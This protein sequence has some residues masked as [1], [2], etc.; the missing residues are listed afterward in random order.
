MRLL[1]LHGWGFDAQFWDGLAAALP[2][3]PATRM[4]RGYFH[5][6]SAAMPDKPFV[7]ITHSLGTMHLLRDPPANCRGL[8]AINGFDCFT[9][10]DHFPGVS[11][12][13]VTRMLTQLD[14]DPRQVLADFRLKCGTD[15]PFP[16]PD[17]AKLRD[18]LALLFEGDCRMDSAQ[19]D[20]PLLA[21]HGGQDPILPADMREQLFSNAPRREQITFADGGHLL[22][23]T[24]TADCAAQIVT[25]LE[26]IT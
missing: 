3:F 25:W 16:D 14:R 23:L 4:D 13:I 20:L 8:V 21:L 17:P 6:P 10:Q 22:P 26:R 11:P 15:A 1:F 2:Q 19:W 12:R 18:D 5:A 7:A 9:A 24:H